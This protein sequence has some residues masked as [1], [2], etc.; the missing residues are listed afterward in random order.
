MILLAH[1]GAERV[2]PFLSIPP[3]V[4]QPRQ[5]LPNVTYLI[6]RRV[7]LR[8]M[9]FVPDRIM[10]QILVYLLAVIARRE[11]VEVHAFCAMSPPSMRA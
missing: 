10:T 1:P 11:G 5:V 2:A 9:L 4:S 8:H 3:A 6:T 7:I